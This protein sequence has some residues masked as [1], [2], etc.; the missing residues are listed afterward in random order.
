[1]PIV[2]L[3]EAGQTTEPSALIPLTLG[4]EWVL[5]VA[6]LE[7]LR[8]TILSYKAKKELGFLDKGGGSL[9]GRYSRNK[10]TYNEYL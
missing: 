6:D 7:Q 1:M 3:D 8:P 9:Y 5:M 4:A 10:S 2:M